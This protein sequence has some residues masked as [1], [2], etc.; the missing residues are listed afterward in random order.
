M[1]NVKSQMERLESGLT[2]IIYSMC[3]RAFELNTDAKEKQNVAR[4][5]V[6]YLGIPAAKPYP[7]CIYGQ[8]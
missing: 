7:V 4:F 8:S 2:F 1:L 6:Y 5:K 3:L